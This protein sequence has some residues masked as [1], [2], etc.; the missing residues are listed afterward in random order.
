MRPGATREKVYAYIR[1][2]IMEGLPPSIR[3]V[4][5]AFN[6]KS[7]GTA[8]EHIDKLVEEGRIERTDATTRGLKLPITKGKYRPE[9]M[10]PIM[11]VVQAGL[12]ELA[13]E[14]PCDYIPYRSK[15]PENELFALKVRGE[16]MSKSGIMPGDYVI[17][18][19]QATA[20]FGQIVV[21]FLGSEDAT[22]KVL[23]KVNGQ[24]ELYATN[25]DYPVLVPTPRRPLTI[26]G[27]VLE[28][29]RT[30][31]PEEDDD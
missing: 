1:K 17:V 9:V 7:V 13:V 30:V 6:F 22:I 18:R 20:E 31:L 19:K 24:I 11:G 2:K 27:V 23:R 14:E 15:H 28:V 4:Q 16:S 10:V 25:T 29:R 5:R 21:A 3:E 8:R 26:A 12:P